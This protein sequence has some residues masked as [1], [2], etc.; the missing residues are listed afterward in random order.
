MKYKANVN[1]VTGN[2]ML[3]GC[4]NRDVRMRNEWDL[5]YLG[6]RQAVTRREMGVRK[7]LGFDR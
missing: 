1:W 4:G 3:I 6:G 5:K 7:K 2:G